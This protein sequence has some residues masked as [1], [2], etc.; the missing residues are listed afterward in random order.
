MA[1]YPYVPL[2]NQWL[3]G[4]ELN[5]AKMYA[6]IDAQ[7]NAM[8]AASFQPPRFKGSITGAGTAITGSVPIPY[9]PIEDTVGG[10]N[11]S[12]HKYSVA[13]AGTYLVFG[14]SKWSTSPGSTTNLSIY[15]NGTAVII[16]PDAPNTNF[17]GP[18]LA[19][20]YRFALNDSV[21]AQN[22]HGFTTQNDGGDNNYLVLVWTGV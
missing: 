22:N 2:T 7:L 16:S 5:A 12:T 15:L 19:T 6:R 13:L 1:V 4:E 3:D 18:Q 11:N 14:A 8:A 10:W 9:P 20:S 21:W 17:M